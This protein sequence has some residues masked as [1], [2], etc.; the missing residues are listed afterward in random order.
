MIHLLSIL[1]LLPNRADSVDTA[2]EA[3]V[4]AAAKGAVEALVA[5]A[6]RLAG[7]NEALRADAAKPDTTDADNLAWFSKRIALV[8]VAGRFNVDAIETLS[9]DEIRKQVALAAYP[10]ANA[11]GDASYFAAMFDVASAQTARA[12]ST[13]I[14]RGIKPLDKPDEKRVDADDFVRPSAVAVQF[15]RDN[16]INGRI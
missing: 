6:S 5:D 14:G 8:E 11:E 7:E 2:D 3:A 10:T 16:G 13:Q 9:D 15:I 4:A 12:D 1:A